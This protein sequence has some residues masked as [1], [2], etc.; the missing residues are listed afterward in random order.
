MFSIFFHLLRNVKGFFNFAQ[1]WSQGRLGVQ[2]G[3]LIEYTQSLPYLQDLG[4]RAQEILS[5][6]R[7]Q[8]KTIL[9]PQADRRTRE[10]A[11]QMITEVATKMIYEIAEEGVIMIEQGESQN[12]ILDM[13]LYAGGP[14]F[15]SV[16]HESSF[17]KSVVYH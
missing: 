14:S 4:H 12:E 9:N 2:C 3:G 5:P 16:V 15:T 10:V 8:R 17:P 11:D 6:K 7:T 13:E 1:Q